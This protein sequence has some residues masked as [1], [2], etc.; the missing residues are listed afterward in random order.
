MF[1]DC[2]TGYLNDLYGSFMR[3]LCGLLLVIVSICSNAMSFNQASVIFERLSKASNTNLYLALDP[4]ESVNAHQSAHGV[5]LNKGMLRFVRN[6]D[7]MA[8]VLGHEIGHYVLGHWT[9]TPK[10]EYASDVFGA[11][12]V[13]KAGYNRCKGVLV[14]LRFH[15]GDSST[16]PASNKRYNRIKC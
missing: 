16:H 13:S 5:Y 12:L 14:I 8:M 10:N 7:E 11:R 3:Y 2:L 15:D 4:D 1:L 9:S 6:E